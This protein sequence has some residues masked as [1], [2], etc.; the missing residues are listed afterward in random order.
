MDLTLI[1]YW[2]SEDGRNDEW[3]DAHDFV[4]ATWDRQERYMVRTYLSS[5]T[6]ARAYRGLSPCRF[7]GQH[8]GSKLYTDGVYAWPEG[9]AHYIDEH[10]VRLPLQIV[11]H[12]VQRLDA[13]EDASLN[14]DWWRSQG[15]Q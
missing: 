3:P 2:R 12:V 7:C 4:D 10:D 14:V 6:I 15:A 13:V 8:N 11:Q 5:G 1:G 9:L